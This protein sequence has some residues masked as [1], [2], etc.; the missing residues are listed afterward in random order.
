MELALPRSVGQSVQRS[1]WRDFDHLLL[2]STLVLIGFGL[3]V[4]GSVSGPVTSWSN[5]FV[6]RQSGAVCV[7]LVAM[8]VVTLLNYRLLTSLAAPLYLINLVL[9]VLVGRFGVTEGGSTRWFD[10]GFYS[11][12]PSQ[13]AQIFMVIVLATLLAR[14]GERL[15]RLPYLL[16]SL[17][18][19]GLPTYFIYKQ[20]DLGSSLVF[21]FLWF[22]MVLAARASWRHILGMLVLSVP[23][24]WFSWH[25]L[26][27]DYM[28]DRFLIFLNPEA[29]ATGQGFNIIQ[30]RIAIGNG[31]F[32]GQG[33]EGGSQSQLEFLKVQ[34]IDFIFAATSEQF[35]FIG[36]LALFLLYVVMI[37]RCLVVAGQSSDAFGQ[38]LCVG[39]AAILFF[40]A[41]VN[42]G[43]NVGVMPVTGVPLPFLSYGGSS[44][45]VLL[46]LQGLVQSVAIRRRKLTF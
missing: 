16:A 37:W 44:I 13:F 20:P 28:R 5:N 43:M 12:Q 31:G 11:V 19:I 29:D 9:L 35:G 40:L 7:G 24:V 27:H 18:I 4:I 23:G 14:W 33:L 38:Y 10:L 39:A 3:V 30:A 21:G 2:L 45:V 15:R 25:Y 42:I 8:G 32:L 41:F 46:A 34:Q 1:R 36:S 22:V 6:V 17:A 26:A